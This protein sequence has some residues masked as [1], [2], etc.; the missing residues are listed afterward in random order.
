MMLSSLMDGLL[1]ISDELSL[2]V[3]IEEF[4]YNYVTANL[5]LNACFTCFFI[6][7]FIV[8]R[9]AGFSLSV[10]PVKSKVL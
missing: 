4:G 6:E 1:S 2:N 9:S 10:L 8:W 5:L 7:A 3:R